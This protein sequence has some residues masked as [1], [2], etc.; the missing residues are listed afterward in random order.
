[1]VWAMSLCEQSKP[2]SWAPMISTTPT[3]SMGY[4]PTM[5]EPKNNTTITAT[6]MTIAP[7]DERFEAIV[8][9]PLQNIY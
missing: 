7:A 6:A 3:G 2:N 4:C 1:M 8:P 9:L 5:N